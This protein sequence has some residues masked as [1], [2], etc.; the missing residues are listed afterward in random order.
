MFS[1]L[2]HVNLVA[3]ELTELDSWDVMGHQDVA[4]RTPLNDD[5]GLIGR[6]ANFISGFVV[7]G[8]LQLPAI[9]CDLRTDCRTIYNHAL[10]YKI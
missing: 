6:R 5:L 9:R 1:Y 7:H 8:V 2:C 10:L 3:G 4:V